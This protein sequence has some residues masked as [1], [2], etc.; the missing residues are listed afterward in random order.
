MKVLLVDVDST[1]FPNLALMKWSGFHE[2][3]GNSVFF[4]RP[5]S[6]DEVYISCVFS[7][8]ASIARGI[9]TM[10]PDARIYLGGAGLNDAVLP[11]EVEH[12]MPDY[13][14]YGIDY[15]VGYL[16]RG[17]IRNCPWCIVPKIEGGFKEHAE[18]D[19][20]LEPRHRKV[21]LMDNNLLASERVHEILS[22]LWLRKLSVCFTQGLD[23]RLVTPDIARLLSRIRGR[24]RSWK[25]GAFYFSWDDPDEESEVI[26]GI[27]NLKKLG[28]KRKL[29]FYILV[30]FNTSW[31]DDWHRVDTLIKLGCNPFVMR[32]NHRTDDLNLNKLSKW[33]NKMYYQ[34]IPFDNFDMKL[35]H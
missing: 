8:N 11:H 26:E 28:V 17:C 22:A 33:V 20:F 31:E 16:T 6:P 12:A 29:I 4:R 5:C 3:I 15:S 30:G 9:A 23:I 27:S 1:K 2:R 7:K 35:A 32:Y 24:T 21:V 13:S 34:F 25:T 10:F 14:L 19:E 18:L